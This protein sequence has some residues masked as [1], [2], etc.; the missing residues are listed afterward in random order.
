MTI[1]VFVGYGIQLWDVTF[2]KR[3]SDIQVSFFAHAFKM[4]QRKGVNFCYKNL[5]WN[6]FLRASFYAEKLQHNKSETGWM[7]TFPCIHGHGIFFMGVGLYYISQIFGRGGQ[8]FWGNFRILLHFYYQIF[9]E[10]LGWG[11]GH[12]GLVGRLS[13]DEKTERTFCDLFC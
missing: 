3:N 10:N 8:F 11:V 7:C 4:I 2:K 5:H 9:S 1:T 12:P 6:I 13:K